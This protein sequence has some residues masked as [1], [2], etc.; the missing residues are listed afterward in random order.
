MGILLLGRI[1]RAFEDCE[2]GKRFLT[3]EGA[4]KVDAGLVVGVDG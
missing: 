1:G 4:L 2:P 3:V